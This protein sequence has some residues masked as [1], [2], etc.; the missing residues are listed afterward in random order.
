[1]EPYLSELRVFG[2]GGIPRGWLPC[3]GQ[4]LPIQ[5]NQALFSLLGTT[6]G[7]NGTTNFGLPNLQGRAP[8]SYGGNMQL[9]TIAGTE[10]VALL[11]PNL[12]VHNH[13]LNAQTVA[14]SVGLTAVA[15]D[16]LL[17]AGQ[18]TP[19]KINDFTTSATGLVALAPTTIT[20]TGG[21]VPHSNMQPYSVLNICICTSGIFPS[22]N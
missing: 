11:G 1:M 18:T 7:G 20:Q 22:R 13:A 16:E 10:N 2:F 9:G 19:D 8:V 14:G 4:I 12:P 15:P 21:N 5:Q 6:Y 3:N 17:A